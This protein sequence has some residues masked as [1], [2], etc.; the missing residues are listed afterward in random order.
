MPFGPTRVLIE[1]TYFSDGNDLSPDLLRRPL[2]VLGAVTAAALPLTSYLYVY[3]RGGAHPE[4][5]GTGTW[6]SSRLWAL[7]STCASIH[8]AAAEPTV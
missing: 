1:D 2:T 6:Q 4:W 5:W 7:G 8:D 3:V